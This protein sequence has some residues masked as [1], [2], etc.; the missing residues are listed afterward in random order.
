MD[1]DSD[2]LPDEDFRIICVQ[3]RFFAKIESGKK[4]MHNGYSNFW[5]ITRWITGEN[6]KSNLLQINNVHSQ[7]DKA[8]LKMNSDQKDMVASDLKEAIDGINHLKIT[9]RDDL[10]FVA[11]IEVSVRQYE[12]L[13]NKLLNG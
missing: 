2:T 13:K 12:N 6:R 4:I 10:E 9:Y 7:I 3:L 1:D 5:A 11:E 8:M